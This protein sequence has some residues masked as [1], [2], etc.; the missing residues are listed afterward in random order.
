MKALAIAGVNLR[1]LFRDRG[2]IFFVLLFPLLL[3]LVIGAAFGG[4]FTPRLGVV[5]PDG[6]PLADQLVTALEADGRVE[7]DRVDDVDALRTGVERGLLAGGLIIP[8]GYDRAVR[9]AAVQSGGSG[10]AELSYLARPDEYGQQVRLAVN[11]VVAE[12]A[13]RLRAAGFAADVNGVPFDQALDTAGE[14]APLVPEVSVRATTVGEA[15]FP[16]GLGRFD[17]GASSQ[18][19]LFVFLTS[20]VGA[21]A[22][23]ETRRYGVSRRMLATPTSTR[24]ILFG[25]ALGRIAVALVQGLIIMLG[26]ALLFGVDWGDPLGAITVLAV[27][28]LVASGAAMVLGA[29]LRT[30][31]QASGIGI[32]VGLG[33]AALGGSMLP[34]ELFSDTMRGVARLT[35]HAW[36]NEAFAELVRHG[37][38]VIDIAPQLAV[39]CGYGV[40]LFLLGSWLLRRTLTR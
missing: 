16:E 27:F 6:E 18:L 38:N 9:D 15:V 28:A 19:L 39:L 21:T 34:I 20:L 37:G 36:A 24:T 22:L 25:E 12:Q 30:E 2:N 11:A 33:L 7:V 26:A 3:I 35:P 13:A 32:M 40:V 31:Q 14:V 23:I 5:A 29:V 1:G 8:P 4:S 10:P 17:L